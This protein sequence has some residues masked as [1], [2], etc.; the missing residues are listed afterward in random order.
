MTRRGFLAGC[1]AAPFAPAGEPEPDPHRGLYAVWA[2]PGVAEALPFLKGGQVVAQ[3]QA[4][5]P[6]EGR[7]DFSTLSEQLG[8]LAKLGRSATVQVNGNRHPA[9]LFERVPSHPEK[10]SR[11]TQDERT[12]Q[13][14]HP[15]YIRAYVNLIAAY[16]RELKNSPHRARIAGVRLNFNALGTEHTEVPPQARDPKSWSAPGPEWTRELAGE[17]RRTVV[18]AFTRYFAPDIRVF[19]RAGALQDPGGL[20]L[21]HTSSEIEPRSAGVERQYRNF[22]DYCRTGRTAG[23][24]ESWADA[25][26][27][28]GGVRDPRWCGP[29][30]YNY[31]R[32][33]SDLNMGVSMIAIYGADLEQAAEPEFRD[34]FAFAARYAGYHASPSRAPG[35]WVA[36]R[37]GSF[38]KGDYTYLMSRRGDMAPAQKAGPSDQRYGA[39]ARVL[40]AGGRAEF[41]LEA[42]FARA[43]ESRPAVLRAVYLDQGRGRFRVRAAGKEFGR[44]LAGTG[45]WVA[46][47]MPLE[48]R[49]REIQVASDAELVLHMIEVAR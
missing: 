20:A 22:L 21:F 29:A 32:L 4:V 11:Q 7:Y 19:A 14:W 35:A 3:W 44:R 47:E 34:A 8:R 25:W 49:G 40:A 27:R 13:Y 43:M 39:W 41:V 42:A 18:D 26:G 1:A 17:Y 30:Q 31:W 23:Y 9:Y 33:L 6:E 16:A 12:L 10:F 2:K 37:E 15:A 46:A 5:E 28:H 48:W 24:A 45:R 38:L 36:L